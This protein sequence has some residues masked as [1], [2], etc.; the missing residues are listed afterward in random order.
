LLFNHYKR[1]LARHEIPAEPHAPDELHEQQRVAAP[2]GKNFD[3]SFLII[4]LFYLMNNMLNS[5]P[6]TEQ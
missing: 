2:P 6:E 1:G 4:T 3:L 5:K